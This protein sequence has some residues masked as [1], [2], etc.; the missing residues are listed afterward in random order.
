MSNANKAMVVVLPNVVSK[1]K[2]RN[3]GPLSGTHVY[4]VAHVKK[5]YAI[6]NRGA[7]GMWDP[8]TGKPPKND[9][10]TKAANVLKLC[11]KSVR[12]SRNTDVSPVPA[13][14]CGQ[15]AYRTTEDTNNVVG[16]A[17]SKT[18]NAMR[19]NHGS[20]AESSCSDK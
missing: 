7:T 9:T 12:V 3:W 18:K 13:N 20:T 8:S 1:K 15:M 11:H 5:T 16:A 2:Y 4:M 19:N 6:P 14:T 17:V 10:S